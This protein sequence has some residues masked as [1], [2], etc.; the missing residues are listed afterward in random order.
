MLFRSS[1]RGENAD[2]PSA[3]LSADGQTAIVGWTDDTT[4]SAHAAVGSAGRWTRTTLGAGYWA[5][6]VRVGAGTRAAAAGWA[7]P[8]AGNPNSATLVG[9][10]WTGP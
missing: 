4:N 5:G 9:R 8:A 3:A 6:L 2:W 10:Y 7:V 1:G